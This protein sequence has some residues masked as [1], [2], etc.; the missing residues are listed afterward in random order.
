MSQQYIDQVG[1]FVLENDDQSIAT[2]CSD[3][4]IKDDNCWFLIKDN[5]GDVYRIDIKR[6]PIYEK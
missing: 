1:L 6:T 5:Y 4:T 3:L 2:I